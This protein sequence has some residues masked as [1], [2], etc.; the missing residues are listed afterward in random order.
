VSVSVSLGP[1]RLFVTAAIAIASI[2][3]CRASVLIVEDEGGEEG[4]CRLKRLEE[5]REGKVSRRGTFHGFY[6][7]NSTA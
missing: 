2:N 3:L 5:E 1:Y 7:P 4:K 6:P